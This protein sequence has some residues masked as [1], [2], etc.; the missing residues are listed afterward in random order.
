MLSWLLRDRKKFDIRSFY[1]FDLLCIFFRKRLDNHG[2]IHRINFRLMNLCQFC[3][4]FAQ[5]IFCG[6]KG[7]KNGSCCRTLRTYQINLRSRVTGASLEVPVGGSHSH[8]LG[9]R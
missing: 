8:A 5:N 9:S 4:I 1:D 2:I 3:D 7:S 6:C